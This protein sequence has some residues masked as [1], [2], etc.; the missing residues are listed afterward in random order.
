M[1]MNR[2]L[3][4]CSKILG[5]LATWLIVKTCHVSTPSSTSIITLILLFPASETFTAMPVLKVA[6]PWRLPL[7]DLNNSTISSFRRLASNLP[8]PNW[9]TTNLPFLSILNGLVC[10]IASVTVTFNH[11][12]QQR[13]VIAFF[14]YLVYCEFFDSNYGGIIQRLTEY[15]HLTYTKRDEFVLVK[16]KYKRHYKTS[17]YFANVTF[18]SVEINQEKAY[19]RASF[20]AVCF[21]RKLVKLFA[22]FQK[23]NISFSLNLIAFTFFHI[24]LLFSVY[25]E[26]KMPTAIYEE[27]LT[28]L[29]D[30]PV[31]CG[32]F[33]ENP[34]ND[35][36]TFTLHLANIR[37]SSGSL[38]NIIATFHSTAKMLFDA[39]YDAC[40]MLVQYLKTLSDDIHLS[41]LDGN[42]NHQLILRSP[43]SDPSSCANLSLASNSFKP[44][45]I[46]NSSFNE[47][48][49][50]SLGH[51]HF[52]NSIIQL[53]SQ[54][55]SGVYLFY[56]FVGTLTLS[57][58]FS[59]CFE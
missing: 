32:E 43:S 22:A 3:R 39:K 9:N 55:N 45:F 30:K 49:V 48:E 47:P 10:L 21:L 17:I 8:T 29:C 7:R 40:L 26:K 28:E 51:S 4:K 31:L 24:S 1:R 6:T 2:I 25:S 11:L 44:L 58:Y 15:G 18:S 37:S 13:R 50:A 54:F 14:S 27:L 52:H 41:Q 19:N 20:K 56:H 42:K 12:S 53:I 57:L 46:N 5:H 33:R 16:E 23:G 36:V 38:N 35:S 59:L 34:V